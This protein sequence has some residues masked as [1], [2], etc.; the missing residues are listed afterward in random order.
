M[1]H[2][3]IRTLAYKAFRNSGGLKTKASG[4][5]FVIMLMLSVAFIMVI[6]S[7]VFP[8]RAY[9]AFFEE[10]NGSILIFNQP[11]SFDDYLYVAEIPHTNELK[12]KTD[13]Y[14]DFTY[15]EECLDKY[16]SYL[17]IVF[18]EG[19][20]E[21]VFD[22][23][24]EETPEI[25]TYIREDELI[26]SA[27]KD[28]VVDNILASYQKYLKEQSG[29]LIPI[30]EPVAIEVQGTATAPEVS[31]S[32]GIMT[33]AAKSLAPLL[34]FIAILYAS[35]NSG[36]NIIAGEKEK[37]TFAAILLSPVSRLE[38]IIGDL[39]GV[40][41]AAFLPAL[42]ML[43]FIFLI[44]AYSGLP[45]IM[46]AIPLLL[47]LAILV[48]ALTI[49]ISVISDSVVSAQTAFLPL[50]FIMV[51]ICVTCI[52]S[53]DSAEN[54]YRMIPIYGHFYGLGSIICECTARELI[55]STICVLFTLLISA[56]CIYVSVRLLS[57]ERFTLNNMSDEDHKAPGKKA[58]LTGKTLPGF[59]IDQ[60]VYPLVILSIF[61]T[62]A[63]L[64][65]L[66]KY[67]ST[68]AFA[69]I[70]ESM[71]AVNTFADIF[72]FS[73]ELLG[74][75]LSDPLFIVSMSV[76]YLLMMGCYLIKVMLKERIREKKGKIKKYLAS[77]GLAIEKTTL[78]KYLGGLALGVA[79]MSSVYL[80]LNVTGQVTFEG[81]N[82]SSEVVTTVL[83]SLL[84]WF[85]Q[86]AC[87]ELMFRG[88]MLPR[89]TERTNRI[90]AYFL[91][92]FLFSVLHSM[93]AGYTP[94]ASI[95]LFLI[96]LLFALISYRS[97][98][99][100]ITC[101]AHTAWNFCQGNIYGL[102]VSGNELSTTLIK[103][104]YTKSHLDIVTGGAFGPE[105]GLA[106]TAVTLPLVIL[107]IVLI[108]TD[109]KKTS[110]LW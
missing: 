80:I 35:M 77:L 6:G 54:F 59:I 74:L 61:Q 64:P 33:F 45:G 15:F 81:F 1:N 87:E 72:S 96:A 12:L 85:P 106:V 5:T 42:V 14:Y 90:F 73:F 75:F 98:S 60:A 16:D 37:G 101:G 32:S 79:L 99:I 53:V 38:L 92:S 19:F 44:P 29:K 97:G 40:S 7:Y 2:K 94:L 43:I 86:G 70:V 13:A 83:I 26:F 31:F 51:T 76:G 88:Y 91:S 39:L 4:M 27:R 109:R 9:A 8:W 52:Q 82:T 55:N 93:N 17:V 78:P 22:D 56:A 49:L 104:A 36:T 11:D 107:L 25:L 68:S 18:P 46:V 103:T 21:K 108:K 23:T 30:N 100:W 110:R 62:L 65:V 69:D 71:K 50:F 63:M 67:S 24:S 89:I 105:G 58:K 48:A 10:D 28:Y 3:A 20:D 34:L 102:Q 47:S 95:N 57:S 41:M 84:M 66:I